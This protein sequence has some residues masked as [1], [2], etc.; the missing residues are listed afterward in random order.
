MAKRVWLSSQ[1]LQFVCASM[2]FR[3]F[4]APFIDAINR[5]AIFPAC[6]YCSQKK[7]DRCERPK[8]NYSAIIAPV[9]SHNDN[10]VR[11]RANVICIWVW[12]P[13]WQT[14]FLE[15]NCGH[16]NVCRKITKIVLVLQLLLTG[17]GNRSR[18][19]NS[20]VCFVF[21]RLMGICRYRK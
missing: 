19:R 8:G 9:Q 4:T 1:I 7:R 11:W 15:R 21:W 10:S 20:F 3:L 2:V 12:D 16:A 5:I 6:V 14:N 17:A 13:P 18:A